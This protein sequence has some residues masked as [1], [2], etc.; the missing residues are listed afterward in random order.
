MQVEVIILQNLP[1]VLQ[2][3]STVYAAGKQQI[4]MWQRDWRAE[5]SLQVYDSILIFVLR[6]TWNEN[7]VS[8]YS[9]KAGPLPGTGS[10]HQLCMRPPSCPFG[11]TCEWHPS[12]LMKETM[13][14]LVIIQKLCQRQSHQIYWIIKKSYVILMKYSVTSFIQLHLCGANCIVCMAFWAKPVVS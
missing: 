8:C 6:W 14:C 13:G 2:N 12:I 7:A 9:C 1:I 11:T 4:C 5:H 10:G 3:L